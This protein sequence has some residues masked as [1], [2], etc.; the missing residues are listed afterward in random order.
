[1]SQQKKEKKLKPL[2]KDAFEN[3][4]KKVVTTSTESSNDKSKEADQEDSQT[5][6]SRRSD[7]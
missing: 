1:M 2:D 4:L 6:E 3:I 5:S 7:D